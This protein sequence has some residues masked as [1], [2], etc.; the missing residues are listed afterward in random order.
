M[1]NR[2]QNAPELLLGLNLFF[3]GFLD[4]TDEREIGLSYGPIP[5]RAISE[6]CLAHEIGGEQRE[7]FFFH[8]KRLDTSYLEWKREQ[9][10]TK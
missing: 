6:Y 10:V 9:K 2:V 4:L 3:S 8:I 5:W 7:D 1:P